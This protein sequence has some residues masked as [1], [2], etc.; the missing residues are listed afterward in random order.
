MDKT[1]WKNE[2]CFGGLTLPIYYK[3]IVNK[4][5]GIIKIGNVFT[6]TISMKYNGPT[7][8]PNRYKQLTFHK[9]AR[10]FNKERIAISMTSAETIIYLHQ[11]INFK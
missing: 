5:Y 6:I 2:Y 9:D 1:I 10:Q 11:N 3:H 4:L 7:T 8:D